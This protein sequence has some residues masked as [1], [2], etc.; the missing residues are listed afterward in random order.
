[1][2]STKENV[3]STTT[4]TNKSINPIPEGYDS[5]TPHLMVKNCANAIEFYK[6]VFGAVEE[7]RFT[8]PND[9]TKIIHAVLR[10]GKNNS[11]SRILLADEIPGMCESNHADGGKIGSPKTVGGNSVFLNVY[12]EDV[13]EIFQKAQSEGATVIMPLMDAFWGDRYGQLQDP[14]GHIWEVATH[15]KDMTK[16]EMERAAKEAFSKMATGDNAKS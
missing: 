11:N 7:R 2:S 6:K 4:S 10:M 15:K 9:N 1:M 16:E 13:D 8:L 5:V 12:F 14:F 3:L